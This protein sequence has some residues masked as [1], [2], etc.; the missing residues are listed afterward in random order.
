M[1]ADA[2]SQSAPKESCRY[3]W[4]PLG[5]PRQEAGCQLKDRERRSTTHSHSRS[6][7]HPFNR[8]QA[9]QTTLQQLLL[10]RLEDWPSAKL[11]ERKF[12]TNLAGA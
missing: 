3:D 9:F 12:Q 10:E 4:P 11:N 2:D 6:R 5:T 7:I 1:A 8:R